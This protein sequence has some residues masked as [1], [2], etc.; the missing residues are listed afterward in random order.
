MDAFPRLK[1]YL[2]VIK[3]E[4]KLGYKKEARDLFEKTIEELGQDSLKEEYFINF[5]KFEIR[6]KE[7]QRAREIYKFGL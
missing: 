7:Y 1:T 4:V 3:F 2:K 5:G 6:E